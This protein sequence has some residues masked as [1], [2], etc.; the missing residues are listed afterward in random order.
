VKALLIS[1]FF[2][3][4]TAAGAHRVAGIARALAE[5]FE[6]EVVTLEPGYPDPAL[7]DSASRREADRALGIA[8]RRAKAFKPHGASLAWRALREIGMSLRLAWTARGAADVV[9]VSTPSMFLGP[10]A[11]LRARL[12]GARFVWDVRDLTWR[13]A[14]ESVPA[15][16]VRRRA[17]EWLE[18][19]MLAI[20]RRADLV[21]AAT[22]GLGEVLLEQ[23]VPPSRLVTIPNGVSR[24]L[25]D[26]LAEP[27]GLRASRRP[28]VT[29]VGLMGYNHRIGILLD[30]ARR[31]PELEFI[32][33]GDGP[34]RPAI[35]ERLR[36]EPL[37]NVRL[38]GYVVDPGQLVRL[39]RDS[40]VLVN[41][42]QNAPILNRI[43]N[44]AK[45]FEYFASGKPVVYAGEGFAARFLTERDLAVVVPPGD[46]A[47]LAAGIRR[48]LEEPETAGVRSR[49]ARAMVEAEF[50][51]EAQ[52]E[53]LVAELRRRFLDRARTER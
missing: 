35:E 45:L 52:M 21:I 31:M 18:R 48:V 27:H 12:S 9:V 41:H 39:Y 32:L 38:H 11:W 2:P 28:R 30:V 43:V 20:L 37:T 46:P 14:L 3:P 1:Q 50:T 53:K 16:G 36:R 19:S 26:G 40:D 4:E 51:R 23:G 25:L 29:Y 24:A 6:L 5:D 22:P 49:R 10:V 34:E 13:Y 7:Y 47:A 42:T 33:V 44:P 15:A 17:L 8:I